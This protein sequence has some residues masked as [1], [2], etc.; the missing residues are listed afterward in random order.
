MKMGDKFSH[1]NILRI[2]S[3]GPV[4]GYVLLENSILSE[5]IKRSYAPFIIF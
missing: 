1:V 2:E 5:T 3:G 4:I